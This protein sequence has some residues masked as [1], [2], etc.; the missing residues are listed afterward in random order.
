VSPRTKAALKNVI[1]NLKQ[2]KIRMLEGRLE[3]LAGQ[4]QQIIAYAKQ[5]EAKNGYQSKYISNLES[6]FSGKINMAN[7]INVGLMKELEKYKGVPDEASE[8][9]V[10]SNNAKG[11]SGTSV[12]PQAQ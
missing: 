3:A 11:I 7:K 4:C 8:G 6:E 2:S 5:L 10:K 12:N 1:E 9:E